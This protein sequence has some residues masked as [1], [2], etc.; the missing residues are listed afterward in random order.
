MKKYMNEPIKS[1]INYMGN[2]LKLFVCCVLF[3]ACKGQ[4]KAANSKTQQDLEP[5]MSDTFYD[6]KGKT[7]FVIRSQKELQAF[8]VEVN[9]T[10]KPGLPLP[11]VDFKKQI[12]VVNT[13]VPTDTHSP[14]VVLK[15]SADKLVLGVRVKK[16]K[17]TS[18]LKNQGVSKRFTI[19]VLPNNNKEILFQ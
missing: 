3:L 12:M 15:D 6:T 13:S 19:Y 8:F 2:I 7:A 14:L 9:K 1:D 17:T 18:G 16:D 11:K 5:L 10:R 4:D